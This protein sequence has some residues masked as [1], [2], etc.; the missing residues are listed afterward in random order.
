MYKGSIPYLP[1]AAS[2]SRWCAKYAERNVPCRDAEPKRHGPRA[3]LA[4]FPMAPMNNGR[5]Q[6]EIGLPLEARKRG[7]GRRLATGPFWGWTIFLLC[8]CRSVAA[9]SASLHTGASIYII[10]DSRA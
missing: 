1:V 10:I 3:P 7:G 4:F 8:R 9:L 2:I 5:S 6:T